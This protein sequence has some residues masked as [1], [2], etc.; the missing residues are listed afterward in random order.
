MKG[1]EPTFGN[2][3]R[4]K[5]AQGIK[6]PIITKPTHNDSDQKLNISISPSRQQQQP[7]QQQ[8]QQPTQQQQQQPTQQQQQQPT[9]QQQ[10]QPTQQQQQQP[11]QQQQQPTQQNRKKTQF[12]KGKQY[13]Q[14]SKLQFVYTP[15]SKDRTPQKEVTN[16][17]VPND[18]MVY[19]ALHDTSKKVLTEG[20]EQK[21]GKVKSIKYIQVAQVE[22][23][24]EECAAIASEEGHIEINGEN[25][26]IFNIK[27]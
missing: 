4:E 14:Q 10:Q 13:R 8:Q 19:V 16:S 18:N 5:K 2:I 15:S 7:T 9:Q 20:L 27:S 25:L 12:K 17:I 21:Y 1:K 6:C 24:D 22:F 23:Y 26:Q 3:D 11:T